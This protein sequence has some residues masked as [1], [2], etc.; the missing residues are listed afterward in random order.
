MKKYFHINYFEGGLNSISDPRNIDDNELAKAQGI[1]VDKRGK[2]GT[3]GALISHAEVPTQAAVLCPASGLKVFSSDHWREVAPTVVDLMHG[4]GNNAASDQLT[5]ANATTSWSVDGIGTLTSEN[6]EVDGIAAS[7]T[8]YVLKFVLGADLDEIEQAPVTT[9]VGQRYTASASV[10]MATGT[11]PTLTRLGIGTTF[12]GSDLLFRETRALDSWTTLT[13]EFTATTTATYL[14]IALAGGGA[15]KITYIDNVYITGTT[16]ND[17][18]GDWLALANAP[19]AQVDLY[20][21]SDDSFGSGGQLDFGTVS[22]YAATADTINFPATNEITDS[23]GQFL[24]KNMRRGQMWKISGC[25]TQTANN[26]LIVLSRVTAAKIYLRGTPLTVAADENGTVTFTKYNPTAFHFVNDALRASPV[27]GGVA[28]RPKHYS[29]VDRIHFGKALKYGD[30]YSN[31]YLNDVGP[32]APTD[33]YVETTDSDGGRNITTDVDAGAGFEIAVTDN[34]GAGE[35]PAGTWEVASSFIYDDG[36]ESPLYVPSTA[37][38]FT[39]TEGSSQDIAVRG[40]NTGGSYDERISGARFYHRKTL[41]DDA[42]VLLADVDMRQGA[43]ATLSGNYNVWMDGATA[44][45]VYS[46]AFDSFK[47]NLD[48]YESLTG[49]YP[50][51]T[52]EDFYTDGAGTTIDNKW[53]S[54]SLIAGDRCFLFSPRY[55]DAG[56]NTMHFADHVLYSERGRY[57]IFPIGNVYQGVRGDADDYVAGAFFNGRLLAFKQRNLFVVNIQDRNDGNWFPEKTHKF[58]GAQRQAAIFDTPYGPAW[59]NEWGVW[60]FNGNEVVDLLKDKVDLDDWNTFWTDYSIVGYYAKADLLII[61]RDATGQGGSTVPEAMIF[62]FKLNAWTTADNIFDSSKA[63]T[64]FET[65]WNQDLIIGVQ[66]NATTVTIQKF[67]DT[68]TAQAANGIDIIT[69]DIDLGG[70]PYTMNEID[71]IGIIYKSSAGQSDAIDYELDGADFDGSS[72]S[73]SM[74]LTTKTEWFTQIVDLTP[75]EGRTISLRIRNN[76]NSGTLDIGGLMVRAREKR[77]DTA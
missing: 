8:S 20:N 76:Q 17:I 72:P 64:N 70:N 26:I 50:S 14:H 74:A 23:T 22:T 1:S 69:K 25:T 24:N 65:D 29:F 31:W 3:V 38:T 16:S 45:T 66:T 73:A 51:D 39:T 9:V 46:H 32:A 40:H 75:V 27:G 42:W 59:C 43:R 56:G 19:N 35:W 36:Q 52:V 11:S 2:I 18:L 28:L 30:E 71:Q 37:Q 15:G 34:A 5:E 55:T 13:G 41:S 77:L 33:Q 68:A 48:T 47:R 21:D 60:L 58:R 61:M 53:W 63:Y 6:D 49:R 57:D 12:L 4:L 44:N 10:Y 7:G 54:A 67:T 62:N